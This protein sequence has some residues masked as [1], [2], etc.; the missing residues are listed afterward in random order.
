MT[1]PRKTTDPPAGR[2]VGTQ[3]QPMAEGRKVPAE[4]RFTLPDCRT[5]CGICS[6]WTRSGGACPGAPRPKS[7]QRRLP[8]CHSII[9]PAYDAVI[10]A[11]LTGSQPTAE[12]NANC[13][14]CANRGQGAGPGCL[15]IDG[16]H[17][18]VCFEAIPAGNGQFSPATGIACE[19]NENDYEAAITPIAAEGQQADRRAAD[20]PQ[21]P[22]SRSVPPPP[23][24]PGRFFDGRDRAVQ[25]WKDV[26]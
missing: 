5:E 25:P 16:D 17:V 1:E 4:L 18:P 11:A 2:Q 14:R 7:P 26:R 24:G 15:G 19:L 23:T 13:L 21:R 12:T 10:Y 22:A 9:R 3:G 6:H 20:C 8:L